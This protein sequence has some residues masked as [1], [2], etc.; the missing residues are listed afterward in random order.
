MPPNPR[1]P[2]LQLRSMALADLPA[3]LDIDRCSFTLPWSENAYRR[4]LQENEHAHYW[5]AETGGQVVGYAGWWLMVDEAH[6]M[7]IA[8][9]PDQRRRGI[10][11]ALLVRIMEEARAHHAIA[12]TLEVRVSNTGAQALYARHGFVPVGRRKRYY[13]DNHEDALL[14]TAPLLDAV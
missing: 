11:E 5:V 8:V 6:L 2:D 10:A 12:I 3:V 14:L 1:E 4:E 7:T 13:R 9:H